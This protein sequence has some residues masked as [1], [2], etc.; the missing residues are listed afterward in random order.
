MIRAAY[1][2]A[3][4]CT[5]STRPRGANASISSLA[6]AWK[7]GRISAMTRF[8]NA[9]TISF[10]IRAWSSPSS[11]SSVSCHQSENRPEW[12]P[13]CAGQRALPCR[14]RRSRSS[15]L[16]SAYRSTAQP[17]VVST[18]QSSSRASCTSSDVTSKPGSPRSKAD[19]WRVSHVPARTIRTCS[20]S[21]CSSSVPSSRNPCRS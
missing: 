18:Y 12:M 19:S 4:S 8:L 6:I 5:N 20:P 15:A 1:G 11:D 14:N 3:N 16:T 13:F 21:S 9:G 2:S 17:H 10:R 7:V